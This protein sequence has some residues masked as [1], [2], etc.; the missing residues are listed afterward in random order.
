MCKQKQKEV[1]EGQQ[2]VEHKES[3]KHR[4]LRRVANEQTA[5]RLDLKTRCQQLADA[6]AGELIFEHGYDAT[7]VPIEEKPYY[8]VETDA[9]QELKDEI[10]ERL[11]KQDIMD[12]KMLK[13]QLRQKL[14]LGGP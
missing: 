12:L 4:F 7:V 3:L 8:R 10:T 6:V 1:K 9:P 13:L 11:K 14:T 5:D 2:S